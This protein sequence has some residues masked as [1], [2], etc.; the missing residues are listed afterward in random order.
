[1]ES[2]DRIRDMVHVEKPSA[3]VA[4]AESTDLHIFAPDRNL[5]LI[6]RDSE[7]KYAGWLRKGQDRVARIYRK[8]TRQFLVILRV[9]TGSKEREGLVSD[10]QWVLEEDLDTGRGNG[11][12]NARFWPELLSYLEAADRPGM[13]GLLLATRQQ[14]LVDLGV[15]DEFV[16][17]VSV[18]EPIVPW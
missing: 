12:W 11:E 4:F 1:M 15:P 3:L 18:P 13:E 10:V 16:A 7:E 6:V 17:D 9:L 5:S 8:N 14:N 2:S